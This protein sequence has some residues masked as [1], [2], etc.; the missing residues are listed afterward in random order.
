MRNIISVEKIMCDKNFIMWFLM[1]NF[2]EGIDEE[3]DLSMNEI[4]IQTSHTENGLRSLKT[5]YF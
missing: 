2:P 4:I 5:L 1:N 3:N